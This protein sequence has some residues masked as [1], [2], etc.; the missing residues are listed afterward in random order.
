[1]KLNTFKELAKNSIDENQQ[2]IFYRYLQD[3]SDELLIP[4]LERC[5]QFGLYYDNIEVFIFDM[6]ELQRLENE[7]LKT[8]IENMRKRIPM[9]ARYY[10]V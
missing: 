6:K 2:L 4:F 9:G 10:Y 5:N 7:A 1:M 8:E 3:Y